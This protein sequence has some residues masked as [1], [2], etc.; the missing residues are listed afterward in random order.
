MFHTF[1]PETKSWISRNP[2]PTFQPE[3]NLGQLI[4]DALNRNPSRVLQIDT[5]TAREM[6][7]RE[8]RLRAVRVAQSL[9]NLGF[10][11][12]DTAA[13]ACSNSENLAPI[14]LGLMIA[15]VP[16][17]TLPTG[18]HADD[19]GHL[20]GLVQPKL[21]ICDDGVY[22]TLLDAAGNALKMK[23]VVFVAESE[24]KNVRKAEELI[25]PSGSE[26]DFVPQHHGDMR[27]LT[28]IILCTSGT[29]GRPKGVS[30]SQAHIAMV[31]RQPSNVDSA[32][33]IFNFSPLYWG[34]GMFA[35]LNSI[36]TGITRAITRS[37]FNEDI[38]FDI[39]ER[40]KPTRFFSPPT[41]TM[42]LLSHSRAELADFGSLK[43]WGLSGSYASPELRRS[44]GARLPNGKTVNSYASTELGLIAMEMT[45]KENSVGVLMPHLDARVV[46]DDG[47]MVDVGE[48]GELLFRTSLPFLGYYNDKQSTDEII[49]AGGWIRTGDIGYLDEEAFVY[50]VDRKK[51]VI[52]YRGYQ[53]S[54]VDLEAVIERIDGVLQVCVVGIPEMDGSSDLP[55]AVIVK[56]ENSHLDEDAVIHI[57]E[58][59]VSNHKRLR[60]GVYFWPELPL[61]STGKILRR[62]VKEKLTQEIQIE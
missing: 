13:L 50:L 25:E 35:L 42:L 8:M 14:A 11:S 44:V 6:T 12:G 29:T 4:L 5:D 59:Q 46:D 24:R 1:D 9:L 28:G 17:I 62:K 31:L 27:E 54:P 21:V 40:Y 57:V 34:T 7:A 49:E 58:S 61:T 37:L 2:P 52:K 19:L 18:F 60:G 41:H 45:R 47:T 3:E 32:N 43:S 56:R 10:G 55:A 22:K 36:S 26:A 53:M 48:Q 20:L 38:F 30:V 33:L 16:F 23:P 39:L 51:D 15:A